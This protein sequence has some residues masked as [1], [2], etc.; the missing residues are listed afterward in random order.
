MR[1]RAGND[2]LAPGRC[3]LRRLGHRQDLVAG[4]EDAQSTRS[5]YRAKDLGVN[6]VDTA[7]VY[8]Q[9]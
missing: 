9:A 6:F 5:L 1:H 2:R 8:G 7:L 3:R 4:A